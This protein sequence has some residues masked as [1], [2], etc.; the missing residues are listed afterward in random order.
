MV[1]AASLSIILCHGLQDGGG[2]VVT[3][4]GL[5][6]SK[7]RIGLRQYLPKGTSC[8]EAPRGRRVMNGHQLYDRMWAPGPLALPIFVLSS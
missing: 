6:V 2:D 4:S 1:Y 3:S 8:F 7:I 5:R